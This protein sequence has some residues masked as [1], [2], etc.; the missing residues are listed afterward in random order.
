MKVLKISLSVIVIAAIGAGVFFWMQ[1][2]TPPQ[3]TQAPENQFTEKIKQE[4]KQ[5]RGKPDNVFC[6]EFYSI[7]LFHINEFYKQKSFGKNQLE[8]IQW[9]E[10]LESNLYVA[11]AE[12]FIKQSNTVFEG[13]AWKN[14]DLRFIQAEK[15]V[16]Q[17]S[18]LL[19]VG[20]PV[21]K[22]LSNIQIAL[23]KYNEIVS[24]IASCEGFGYSQTDLSAQFPVTD[25]QNRVI[26]SKVLLNNR[27]ENRLVNNCAR[28]YIKLKEIPQVLFKKHI[29]YLDK[30]INNWLGFFSNYNSYKE[31]TNI[32]YKPIKAEIETL[33]NNTYNVY[34][35]D[36]E[37]SNLLKKLND[38]NN[39]A[40]H[41]IYPQ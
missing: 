31:Y 12:K 35:F 34:N 6:N 40:F 25:V 23:N 30:K 21:Y 18:K 11:Y 28:L 15:N 26:R 33:D 14:E 24:F 39:K 7:I 19:L 9:K 5:L 20:S 10:D 38:D 29:L 22:D 41:F 2:N 1:D 37:Y 3:K 16:L 8:N 27:L 36:S 32:Q 13:S 17:E 4:I